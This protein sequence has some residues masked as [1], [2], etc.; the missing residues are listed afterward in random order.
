V[1]CRHW[2]RDLCMKGSACEFLHQYDL[3]KMPLCRHG[4]RCKISDCPF[5]HISEANR[6]ECVFYSQGFCIHGPFCR[7]KHVRRDREDLPLVADFT[8]GLSQMQA[9]SNKDGGQ[10]A[11]RPAPKPNEFYKISLCKH[12]LQ[13][14]CPFGENC[15]FAHGEEELRQ[16]PK[17][18]QPYEDG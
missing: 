7:Y 6:L 12:F 16:F 8:L 3:S 18:T 9:A 17:K 13:G 14:D 4:D 1:V 5:R 2:L 15:H 11:K 10:V